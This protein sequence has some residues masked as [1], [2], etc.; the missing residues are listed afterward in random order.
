MKLSHELAKIF[1]EQM[2]I[3]I[4]REIDEPDYLPQSDFDSCEDRAVAMVQDAAY[5]VIKVL[6]ISIAKHRKE[7]HNEDTDD[8]IK[9]LS[10][11]VPDEQVSVALMGWWQ[12]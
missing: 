12:G 8:E 9:S 6:G 1:E 2:D 10:V 5:R 11:G 3:V 4:Q 7:H